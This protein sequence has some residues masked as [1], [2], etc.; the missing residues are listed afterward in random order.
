MRVNEPE[1]ELSEFNMAIS[2]LNRL[3]ELFYEADRAAI[4]LNAY[5]WFN[6]LIALYRELSTEMNEKE[7]TEWDETIFKINA[8]IQNSMR[9]S[10]QTGMVKINNELYLKL[11]KFEMFLRRIC[12]SSG[13]QNKMKEDPRLSL[14]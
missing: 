11:H 13:L 9:Q 8:S 6:V 5:T 3:N 4:E 7:L 14:M 12:K 2:Y 10:S 1:R